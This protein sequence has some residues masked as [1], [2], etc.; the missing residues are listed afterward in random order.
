MESEYSLWNRRDFLKVSGI[1]AALGMAGAKAATA[2]EHAERTARPADTHCFPLSA[3]TVHSSVHKNCRTEVVGGCL[4][5][6]M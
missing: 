4:A 5:Q 6:E 1:F 3:L 2:Q